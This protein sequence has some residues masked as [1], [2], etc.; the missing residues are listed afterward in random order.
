MERIF[1]LPAHPLMVHFPVVAIPVLCILAILMAVSGRLRRSLGLPTVLLGAACLVSTFMTTRS[2][3]A[4]V[5]PLFLESV[6]KEHREL[7]QTTLWLVLLL[8]VFLCIQFAVGRN[9]DKKSGD[10][11]DLPAMAKPGLMVLSAVVVVLSVLSTVWV[12]R[13]GHEGA[14]VTW[15]GQLPPES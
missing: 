15:A 3:E 6:I 10:S 8:F 7:G 11:F 12:V 2:G 4:L 1:D 5:E 14:K 9:I 13:T